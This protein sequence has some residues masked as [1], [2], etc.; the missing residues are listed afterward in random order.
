LEEKEK[1]GDYVSNLLKSYAGV[2]VLPTEVRY[3]DIE[4]SGL[5]EEQTVWEIAK[6]IVLTVLEK[7]EFSERKL[8]SVLAHIL[9]DLVRKARSQGCKQALAA[10]NSYLGSLSVVK[11]K[12]RSVLKE[13]QSILKS[14]LGKQC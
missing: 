6:F 12:F 13:V 1:I 11:E 8:V 10:V 9:E 3:G 2:E 4:V 14:R 7:R 5:E